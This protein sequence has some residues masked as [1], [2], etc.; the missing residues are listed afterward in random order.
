MPRLF[1][2]AIDGPAASGKSTTAKQLA[3]LFR[4]RYIDSGSM[5]RAVT[6]KCVENGLDP[7]QQQAE[8]GV[9][10]ASLDIQFPEYGMVTVNGHNV[11]SQLRQESVARAIGPIASN[12][13]V[14]HTL[15]EQQRRL[16]CT[17]DDR[18]PGFDKGG[19]NIQGVVMDGRDIGTVILPQAELKIF[20]VA[21]VRARALRR[22]QELQQQH[23]HDTLERVMQD[24]EARDLA[25]RTRT[26]SPLKMAEDAIELDTSHLSIDQQ[27]AAIQDL[28]YQK[29]GQQ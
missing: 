29:L 18:Y 24:I 23:G 27:V 16:A 3:A 7:Q 20:M 21:D 11:T 8:V 10:T 28:V 19:E 5:F 4:F 2:I 14:R 15:S 1:R 26:I 12:P 9:L 13:L 22:F 6:L 25:D 17:L